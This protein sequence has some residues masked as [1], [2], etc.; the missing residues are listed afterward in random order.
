MLQVLSWPL[1][2]ALELGRAHVGKGHAG[3]HQASLMSSG[4]KRMTS[5]DAEVLLRGPRAQAGCDL[6]L[7]LA[8]QVEWSRVD[9]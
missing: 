7:I 3:H 6:A 4:L 9:P 8:F 5:S 1:K 2:A